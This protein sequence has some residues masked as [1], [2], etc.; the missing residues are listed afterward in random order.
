M[1]RKLTLLALAFFVILAACEK[2]NTEPDVSPTLTPTT[3]IAVSEAENITLDPQILA[4]GQGTLIVNVSMPIGYKFNNLAPFK[5][6]VAA[7][8]SN[9]IVD[10]AWTRYEQIEPTMPLQIPLTL[11]EGA[12]ILTLDLTIYWCEAVNESLCFVDER[13]I[14]APITVDRSARATFATAEVSLIPPTY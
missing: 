13:H 1:P 6:Q 9:V 14:T 3:V 12:S 8:G 10:S 2:D 5:A 7:T 4:P 11:N